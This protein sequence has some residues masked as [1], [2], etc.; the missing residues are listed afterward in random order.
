MIF[1]GSSVEEELM[2]ETKKFFADARKYKITKLN[3][4]GK[5]FIKAFEVDIFIPS[6]MK[7]IEFDGTYYHSF[8]FMR[9]TRGKRFWSDEDLTQYHAI[10]DEAFL[11]KNIQILH[12]KEEDWKN[13]KT[14]CIAQIQQFLG[15]T[16]FMLH[17]ELKAA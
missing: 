13:N 3:I 10:K 9:Q 17:D 8:E 14:A 7:G 6:L 15:I 5:T 2:S 16:G 4:L 1:C 12:I 11:S